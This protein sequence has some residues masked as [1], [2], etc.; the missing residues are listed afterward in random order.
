MALAPALE[1]LIDSAT[2]ERAV[3]EWLKHEENA[4]V[5]PHALAVSPFGKYAVPFWYRSSC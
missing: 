4:W 3:L 2:T 1:T 5:L